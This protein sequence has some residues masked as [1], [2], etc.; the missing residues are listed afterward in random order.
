MQFTVGGDRNNYPG[1]VTTRTAEM[2]V[3][4]ML[5]ISVISMK[6][7]RFMTMEISNFYFMIPLHCPEFIQ[8][9]LSD[10]PNEVVVE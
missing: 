10:I 4:K 5:F 9:K 7:T 6:G 8:I 1:E 2:M 3:A